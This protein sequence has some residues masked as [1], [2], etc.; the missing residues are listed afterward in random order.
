MD[1]LG[2][3]PMR[4]FNWLIIQNGSNRC[5][6]SEFGDWASTSTA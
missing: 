6:F 5:S 3:Y 2:P 1:P 4:P